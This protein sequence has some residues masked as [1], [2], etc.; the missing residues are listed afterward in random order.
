MKKYEYD[1]KK[2]LSLSNNG[3]DLVHQ[4]QAELSVSDLKLLSAK[5]FIT[6]RPAGDNEF[7]IKLEPAGLIYFEEKSNKRNEFLLKS[8]F[9]PILVSVIASLTISAIGYF[10]TMSGIRNSNA[11]QIPSAE[12]NAEEMIDTRSS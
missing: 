1:L 11:S 7:W 6:M 10:W 2:L 5:G 12:P 4:E 9:V 8:V 3:C